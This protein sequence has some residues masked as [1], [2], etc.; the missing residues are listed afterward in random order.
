MGYH[1]HPGRD[2][3][4][5]LGPKEDMVSGHSLS[6][7][8]HSTAPGESS[9]H[10]L[11]STGAL[12]SGSVPMIVSTSPEWNQKKEDKVTHSLRANYL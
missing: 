5:S 12:T 11:P 7:Q 1:R 4:A 8:H 3:R 2:T 6:H 9:H 10:R